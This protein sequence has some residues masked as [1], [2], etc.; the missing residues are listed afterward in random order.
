MSIKCEKINSF[1]TQTGELVSYHSET[2][3]SGHIVKSVYTTSM[4]KNDRK[5]PILH[6]ESTQAISVVTG[7]VR[8][9]IKHS[10]GLAQFMLDSNHRMR[11]IIPPD[12][13]YQLD[14]ID[15]CIVI[16]MPNLISNPDDKL[17]TDVSLI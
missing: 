8:I 15:D 12:H 10:D 7:R 11:I 4:K 3:D 9:V 2:Q 5:G 6:L 1:V 14:A 16:N 13:W 17:T